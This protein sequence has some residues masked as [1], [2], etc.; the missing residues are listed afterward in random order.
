MESRIIKALLAAAISLLFGF[1]VFYTTKIIFEPSPVETPVMN[2]NAPAPRPNYRNNH[3]GIDIHYMDDDIYDQEQK[4]YLE[5][6]ENHASTLNAQAKEKE[7][8][9]HKQALVGSL[10]GLVGIIT[11]FSLRKITELL[12]GLTAGSSAVLVVSGLHLLTMTASSSVA[13]I[14][15]AVLIINTLVLGALSYYAE[16][17][18]RA[19]YLK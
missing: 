6:Q 12:V 14:G 18:L 3:P 8:L 17:K 1:T 2:C 5:C 15:F 11:A 7:V 16:T 4:E 9:R 19:N 13:K 10:L